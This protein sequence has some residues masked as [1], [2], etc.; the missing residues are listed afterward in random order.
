MR[1]PKPQG[2]GRRPRS[3]FSGNKRRVPQRRR[4]GSHGNAALA[5]TREYPLRETARRMEVFAVAA[6]AASLFLLLVFLIFIS[7]YVGSGPLHHPL[8]QNC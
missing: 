2:W 1:V 8:P 3:Q 4:R 7:V 5:S 6:A